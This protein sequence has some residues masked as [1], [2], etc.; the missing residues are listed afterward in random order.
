MRL[1]DGKPL[2]A[3]TIDQAHKCRTID[4]VAVSTDSP[5]IKEYAESLGAHVPFLRPAELSGDAVHGSVP[6]L[7]LLEKLG[8]S[9]KYAFCVQL[10]ATSPL[11]KASTIDEV[12]RLALKRRTNVLSVTPTGKILFHMRTLSEDGTL[13]SVM[14][15]KK[16]N[17]QTQDMPELFAI[18]G[19]IYCAPVAELL[20]YR[21]F[22]YGNPVAYVMDYLEAFDIDT[23]T[24]FL[25]CEKIAAVTDHAIL[26]AS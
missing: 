7:H 2:L 26:P 20:E 9:S 6:I 14:T 15:E 5:E 10:L 16:Y 11:K 21:T 4:E 23:E 18:N 3:H 19:A 22:Q 24:D 17:L 1:F 12:V 13:Q 25:T 8:G